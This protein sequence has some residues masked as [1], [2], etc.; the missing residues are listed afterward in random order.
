MA[1]VEQIEDQE[2]AIAL[3]EHLLDTVRRRLSAA[4]RNIERGVGLEDAV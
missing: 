1:R 4:A 2:Q 3:G